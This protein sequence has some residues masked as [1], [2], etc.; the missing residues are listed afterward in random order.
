MASLPP[1]RRPKDIRAAGARW[2][3]KLAQALRHSDEIRSP[4]RPT[5]VSDG[6]AEADSLI[7]CLAERGARGIRSQGRPVGPS[8]QAML[9]ILEFEFLS[10]IIACKQAMNCQRR[11]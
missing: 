9:R 11:I 3:I 7:V 6:R 8:P 4:C 5:P 10:R 1:A 2:L